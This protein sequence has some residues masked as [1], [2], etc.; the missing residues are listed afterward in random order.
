MSQFK[1][2]YNKYKSEV[3]VSVITA[4]ICFLGK[5]IFNYLKDTGSEFIDIFGNYIYYKM[6]R[7]DSLSLIEYIL[8]LFLGTIAC[9]F[10]FLY[11]SLLFK[12]FRKKIE[13]K[14]KI[15]TKNDIL[16]NNQHLKLFISII[17][18]LDIFF[19][20]AYPLGIIYC[21]DSKHN[22]DLKMTAL[23]PYITEEK[24]DMLYSEWVSMYGKKDYKKIQKELFNLRCKYL[25]KNEDIKKIVC[26]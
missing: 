24:Y 21:L 14:K 5:S 25:I 15:I 19:I 9:C 26:K 10:I 13:V 18:F 22:F 3:I 16:Y 20:V 11:I 6:G 17:V 23:K 8:G 2:T 4:F 1:D 12:S 7:I